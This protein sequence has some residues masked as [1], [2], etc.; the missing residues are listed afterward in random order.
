LDDLVQQKKDLA[1]KTAERIAE[2]L[3]SQI[4]LTKDHEAAQVAVTVEL[5]ELGYKKPRAARKAKTVA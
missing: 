1:A 2:L 4:T 5:K 3:E